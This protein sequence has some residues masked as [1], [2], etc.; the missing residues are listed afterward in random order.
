MAFQAPAGLGLEEQ[1][2]R[3]RA[4]AAVHTAVHGLHPVHSPPQWLQA[5]EDQPPHA[6]DGLAGCPV[7]QQGLIV[8]S[9][10]LQQRHQPLLLRTAGIH[11][12]QV[13]PGLAPPPSGSCLG[14]ARQ[15][16]HAGERTWGK[17]D[18]SSRSILGTT[19]FATHGPQNAGA[20]RSTSAYRGKIGL[21]CTCTSADVLRSS[22][23]QAMCE[24]SALQPSGTR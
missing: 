17:K 24:N 16:M 3:A 12:V 23:S 8:Q 14:W 9:I 13:H 1:A 18:R 7:H 4:L 10:L 2:Q 6:D 5:V 22:T 11:E 19:S 15:T 20:S 21:V